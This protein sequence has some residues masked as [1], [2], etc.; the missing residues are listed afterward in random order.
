MKAIVLARESDKNQDSND[1]Q[2]SRI[3]EYVGISGLEEWKIY[4]IKE[5]STKGYRVK[6]QEIIEIIKASKEPIAVVVDTVDRLQRSFRESV[7]FDELRREGKVELHF[8]RENLVINKKSNSA[9]ILRW[10]MG[11]MFAKSY[12]LQLSDN[13]KRKQSKMRED[14]EI[15]NGP[16]LGYTSIYNDNPLRRRRV[17]VVQNEKAPLILE[18]FELYAEGGISVVTLAD[19]MFKKGLRSDEGRKIKGDRIHKILNDTFYYGEAYSRTHDFRYPHKYKPIVTKELYDKCQEIMAKHNKV[20]TKYAAKPF[21]FRGIITCH[22]G[23]RVGGEFKKGKYILYSCSGYKGCKKDYTSEKVLLDQVYELLS[24]LK[25][26]DEKITEITEMLKS[27]EDNVNR[28]YQNSI[29]VLR[30]EHDKYQSRIRKMYEDRLDGRLGEQ[31]YD[32]LVKEYKLKQAEITRQIQNH[33]DADESF[34]LTANMVLSISKRVLPIFQSS[35]IE[36]KRQILDFLL[37]NCT[38]KEK[39]LE[40]TMRSPFNLIF[41]QPDHFSVRK[42]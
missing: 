42:L 10:D 33:S 2:L 34:Y 3:L 39:T 7:L 23:C 19:K 35:E 22:C 30:N 37:Q 32:E 12:V 27:T 4:K 24:R 36:E 29:S 8:Y 14:G 17:D 18:T 1:A 15:T 11:V 16:P 40:F 28:F 20:P 9:D 21:V 41:N 25:L 5:S 26:T 13:L 38:L 6:F 31:E